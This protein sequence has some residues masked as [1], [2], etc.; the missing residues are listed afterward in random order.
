MEK[1]TQFKKAGAEAPLATLESGKRPH[2][3]KETL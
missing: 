2:E 3:Q 1:E